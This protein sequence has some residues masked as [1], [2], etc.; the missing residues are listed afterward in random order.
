MML[1]LLHLSSTVLPGSDLGPVLAG[2]RVVPEEFED[3]NAVSGKC[4]RSL[5]DVLRKKE[6]ET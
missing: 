5:I 3:A 2:D 1:L 4:F 6:R